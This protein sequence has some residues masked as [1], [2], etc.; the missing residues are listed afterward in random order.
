MDSHRNDTRFPPRARG[1][2][3]VRRGND[4]VRRGND[5][6]RRGND[7]VRRGND[8]VRRGNDG[9][10]RGNDGVRWGNDGVRRGKDGV[11]HGNDGVRHGNDG[12]SM[13]GEF[14]NPAFCWFW[15]AVKI[16]LHRHFAALVEEI[17]LFCGLYALC[18]NI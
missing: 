7:G 8:G 16:P 15:F 17:G 2:D 3:G 14:L 6:V 9:V 18:N 12:G 1:N 4:G 5:G 10:R 13:R 11:R